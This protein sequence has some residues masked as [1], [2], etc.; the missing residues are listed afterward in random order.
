MSR[1]QLAYT[2]LL[3][4]ERKESAAGCTAR[5]IAWFANH[6]VTVARIMTDNGSAY[7]SRAF[8]DLRGEQSIKHKRT[9][10]RA[11]GNAERF[12]QTSLCEWAHV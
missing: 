5:M 9:R 6:G 4:N 3:P 12:I 11:N 2:E 7:R 8:R 1:S 10:P